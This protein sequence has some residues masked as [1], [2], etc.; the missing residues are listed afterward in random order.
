MSLAS[1]QIMSSSPHTYPLIS[2]SSFSC[3]LGVSPVSC[4]LT[5]S[6]LWLAGR[7]SSLTTSAVLASSCVA[8]ISEQCSVLVPSI[9]RRMSP[10]CS[11]PHLRGWNGG[12]SCQRSVWVCGTAKLWSI[13]KREALPFHHAGWLYLVNNDNLFAPVYRCGKADPQAGWGTFHNLHQQRA[14]GLLHCLWNREDTQMWERPTR[15]L[16]ASKA[17]CFYSVVNL[18][19]HN[20]TRTENRWVLKIQATCGFRFL[21]QCIT[22]SKMGLQVQ[23]FSFHIHVFYSI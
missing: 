2:L 17:G 20:A 22:C 9:D 12:R 11:A 6:L 1:S 10:T 14:W 18:A 16:H 8:S 15:S 23:L 4:G 7:I 13:I 19:F 3:H 21:A 5:A